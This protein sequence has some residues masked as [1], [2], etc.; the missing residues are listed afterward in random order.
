M[1]GLDPRIH[2]LGKGSWP[3]TQLVIAKKRWTRGSSPIGAKIRECPGRSAA[4]ALRAFTPVFAGYGRVVRCRPGIVTHTTFAKVPDQ[5]RTA[6]L[7]LA[8]HRIRDTRL[9]YLGAYRVKPASDTREMV[10]QISWKTLS[11]PTSR[12]DCLRPPD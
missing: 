8:L 2:L 3:K 7:P 5:R 12:G 6:S 9:A 4:R 10:N 1:R 11:R